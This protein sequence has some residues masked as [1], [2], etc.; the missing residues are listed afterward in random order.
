MYACIYIYI[1]TAHTYIHTYFQKFTFH[2]HLSKSLKP[3]EPSSNHTC[4][5]FLRFK[6][7]KKSTSQTQTHIYIY[8][9]T[10]IRPYIH[11]YKIPMFNF[12]SHLYQI[13]KTLFRTFQDHMHASNFM[14]IN[15]NHLS[16]SKPNLLCV[17]IHTHGHPHIYIHVHFHFF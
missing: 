3:L 8:I 14:N 10:Y 11:T 17:Y 5:D 2:N 1:Y 12:P 9:H 7:N 4:M 13:T 6:S 16:K 15:M